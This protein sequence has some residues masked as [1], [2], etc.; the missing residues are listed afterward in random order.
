M[1]FK[2][3]VTLILLVSLSCNKEEIKDDSRFDTKIMIL[4]HMGMGKNYSWPGDSK[5]SIM[6]CL[7]IGCD[8]SEIDVQMTED[9]VLVA[10]HDDNLNSQ[11]TCAGLIHESKWKDI[12]QCQYNKSVNSAK[13]TSIDDLFASINQ[14]KNFYF[15]FDCKVSAVK[16]NSVEFQKRYLRAVSRLL[17]KYQIE[18]QVFLEGPKEFLLLAK[19]MQLKAYLFLLSNNDDS[20]T[21]KALNYGLFG[22]SIPFDVSSNDL[23]YASKLNIR[24]MVWSPANYNQNKEVLLKKPDIIQTDDP[25]SLLKLCK[26]FNYEAVRP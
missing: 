22:I 13:L 12:Q 17:K 8:G 2:S 25:Y 11:T 21:D 15:S 24:T 26:R 9:S 4:G 14:L 19:E 23:D 20:P 10:Y 6:A 16:N 18:D 5:E 1:K 3:L 7:E